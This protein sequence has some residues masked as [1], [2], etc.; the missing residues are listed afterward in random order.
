MSLGNALGYE[1][2]P[3]R[4]ARALV[5]RL[6]SRRPVA[7]LVRRLADPVDRAVLRMTSGAA[8]ATS[9]LTGLP[10]LWVSTIGA[11]SGRVHRVPLLAI[12]A[13]GALHL[14]GTGFGNDST[15][16]WVHNLVAHPAVRLEH[17]GRSARALATPVPPSTQAPV[18]RAATGVYPAYATYRS[19]ASHRDIAVFRLDP[20]ET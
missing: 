10:V 19:R 3:P 15:P 14:L 5:V 18:W 13:E 11:R 8:T 9:A 2:R 17:R 12:P 20:V 1:M 4:G 6:L 7:S 16:A